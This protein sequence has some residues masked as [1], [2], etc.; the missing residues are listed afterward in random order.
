[1]LPHFPH[2]RV[3]IKENSIY[4]IAFMILRIPETIIAMPKMKST[5]LCHFAIFICRTSFPL[6]LIRALRP[7]PFLFVLLPSLCQTSEPGNS[8]RFSD[9]LRNGSSPF[10][11]G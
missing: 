4:Y 5:T 10:S 3:Y 9:F 1:M 7:L 2:S 8:S 6:P 11:A